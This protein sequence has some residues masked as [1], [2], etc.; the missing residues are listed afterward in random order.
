[1][2]SQ[3]IIES[4]LRHFRYEHL[5]EFLQEVSK[6]FSVLANKIASRSSSHET[7]VSIRKLLESKDAAVRARLDMVSP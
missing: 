4:T 7:Y 3:P 2:S 5:P 6:P 1:M